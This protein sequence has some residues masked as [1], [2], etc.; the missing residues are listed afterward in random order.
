[1]FL[2]AK[3][4]SDKQINYTIFLV[5]LLRLRQCTSHPFMLERTIRESWTSEDVRELRSK[6]AKLK[7]THIAFYDQCKIWVQSEE[8]RKKAQEARD[9]G[10]DVP[11]NLEAMPFGRGTYGHKFTMDKA[12]KTLN[13]VELFERL[14]CPLCSDLPMAP[15]VTEVSHIANSY[16]HLLIYV[17]VW[18][19]I[20]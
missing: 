14:V 12:L 1:M 8:D 10:K 19:Y 11:Q 4:A 7:K 3:A 2:K 20:L 5:Q 18:P 6:L 15:T 9:S 16:S 13:S 17:K